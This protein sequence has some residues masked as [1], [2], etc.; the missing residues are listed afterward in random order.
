MDDVEDILPDVLSLAF[1]REGTAGAARRPP[2]RSRPT[3]VQKT[4]GRTILSLQERR[5]LAAGLEPR[6]IGTKHYLF[7][8]QKGELEAAWDI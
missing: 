1:E 3:A 2:D 4:A 6:N 8:R 5:T 7:L